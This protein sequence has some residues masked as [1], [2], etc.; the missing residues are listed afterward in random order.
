MAKIDR[1]KEFIGLLKAM[2]ITLIVVDT[3]LIAWLFNN[4]NL[5]VKSTIVIVAIAIIS[6]SVIVL[7][8][9]ILK[10]IIELEDM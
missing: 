3:S 9:F 10:K 5:T 1:V 6:F 4:T 2:L 7:F 8:K